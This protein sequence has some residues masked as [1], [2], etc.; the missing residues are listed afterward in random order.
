MVLGP[1]CVCSQSWSESVWRKNSARRDLALGVA[2]QGAIY[3]SFAALPL[4]LG[5]MQISW[6][7]VL[8]GAEIAHAGAFGLQQFAGSLDFDGFSVRAHGE[9]CIR[10]HA[11]TDFQPY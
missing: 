3:G 1:T 7:I 6:M 10:R 5:W 4:F 9:R 2:S 11:L 8:F